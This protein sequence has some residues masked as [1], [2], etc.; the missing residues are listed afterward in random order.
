MAAG[1]DG[2]YRASSLEADDLSCNEVDHFVGI[3]L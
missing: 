1:G 3:Y 2:T